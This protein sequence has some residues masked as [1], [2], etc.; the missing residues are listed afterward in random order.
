METIKSNIISDEHLGKIIQ[1]AHLYEKKLNRRNFLIVNVKNRIAYQVMFRP[2]FFMHL[3]GVQS[4]YD[5]KTFYAKCIKNRFDDLKENTFYHVDKDNKTLRTTHV[6]QK[7][8]V[9]P[10]A[11][12]M[13]DGLFDL[14]LVENLKGASFSCAFGTGNAPSSSSF[15]MGVKS[16]G[17]NS[18]RFLPNTL[19]K[20]RI[21]K[22]GIPLKID[23]IFMKTGDADK[24]SCLSV[25]DS[26]NIESLFISMPELEYL[27]DIVAIRENINKHS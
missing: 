17:K 26:S 4:S 10:D 22:K 12:C 2:Q 16:A 24:Y 23:Y 6:E 19:L 1:N 14:F 27:I 18:V 13:F 21:D 3:A 8:N 15:V 7:N 5:A 9:L 20:A 25:G 11:A